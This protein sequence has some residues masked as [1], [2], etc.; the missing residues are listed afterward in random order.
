MGPPTSCLSPSSR[1]LK[2]SI[3]IP[4]L[5]PNPPMSPPMPPIPPPMPPIPPPRRPPPPIP[6]AAATAMC[7]GLSSFP[8]VAEM[9]STVIMGQW[10]WFSTV[11]MG[12]WQWFAPL[13]LGLAP[14]LSRLRTCTSGGAHNNTESK[15][16]DSRSGNLAVQR[17]CAAMVRPLR[18]HENPNRD[19]KY[20]LSRE[21]R[22]TTLGPSA[23]N[24]VSSALFR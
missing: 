11:I 3:G 6:T 9:Q 16:L 15:S 24:F 7:N 21:S 18:A 8:L 12:Q 17:M 1:F 13:R 4:R 14:S 19:Q 5:R 2:S 22:P 23:L 20:L 10:H